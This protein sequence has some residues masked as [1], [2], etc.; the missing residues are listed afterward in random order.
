[1]MQLSS[2]VKSAIQTRGRRWFNNFM[3]QLE[4]SVKDATII[5]GYFITKQVEGLTKLGGKYLE[6]KTV[7]NATPVVEAQVSCLCFL[8]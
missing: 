7:E 5:V 6:K 8:F 2:K 1:M 3:T 4:A